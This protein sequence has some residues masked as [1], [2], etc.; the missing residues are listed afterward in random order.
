MLAVESGRA[1]PSTRVGGQRPAGPAGDGAMMT[2]GGGPRGPRHA[3]QL[4]EEGRVP[5]A[6]LKTGR[7][8]FSWPPLDA[9]FLDARRGVVPTRASTSRSVSPSTSAGNTE[10][11]PSAAVVMTRSVK[12]LSP[13]FSCHST[14]LLV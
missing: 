2:A 11:A 4:L 1:D 5:E 3:R 8:D 6:L 12:E 14:E 13:S 10:R 7:G 9:R